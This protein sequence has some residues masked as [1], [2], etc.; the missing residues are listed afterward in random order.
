ML[1]GVGYISYMI[2]LEKKHLYSTCH[3]LIQTITT[4][5]VKFAIPFVVFNTDDFDVI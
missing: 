2:F 3:L 4:Q 1:N 5:T